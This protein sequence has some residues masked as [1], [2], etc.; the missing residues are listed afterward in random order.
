MLS[1]RLAVVLH[2]VQSPE[3]LG[4]VAR[5]MANFGFSDLRI[6]EPLEFSWEEARRVAV[7][8]AHL[9]D[10]AQRFTTLTESVGDCVYVCGTTFRSVLEGRQ[11]LSPEEGAERLSAN[12]A[13]GKVALLFGGE[14]RGLSD[15]ELAECQDFVCI[16][17]EPEQ[18]S[19]NL[20]QSAAVMLYLCRR[21]A[22]EA[23]PPLS[24]EGA[25]FVLLNVLQSELGGALER[26]D[27]LNPQAPQYV[28]GELWR[29]LARAQLSRREAEL[30]AAALKHIRRSQGVGSKRRPGSA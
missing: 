5:I 6:S 8:S 17:T 15:A 26:A 16:S 7:K 2:Q 27:F 28:L 4:A 25:P 29:T 18:P 24:E 22:V 13:R 9:L 14:R 10:S 23:P 11:A 1:D 20:A 19:M 12:A 21:P 30:W 3:N